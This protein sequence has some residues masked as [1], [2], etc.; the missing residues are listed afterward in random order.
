M[1]RAAA[2]ALSALPMACAAS[3]LSTSNKPSVRHSCAVRRCAQRAVRL[4][5]GARP[6]SRGGRLFGCETTDRVPASGPS[7]RRSWRAQSIGG[8]R[9]GACSGGDGE[10]GG[11]DCA[12]TTDRV[13]ASWASR[14]PRAPR[15]GASRCLCN[16][17]EGVRNSGADVWAAGRCWGARFCAEAMDRRPAS[18]V[19][20]SALSSLRDD[21]EGVPGPPY[22]MFKVAGVVLGP[23]GCAEAMYRRPPTGARSPRPGR[24]ATAHARRHLDDGARLALTR[25]IAVRRARWREWTLVREDL[26]GG[27]GQNSPRR[28]Q[29][30][31]P[32]LARIHECPGRQT[33]A[34]YR[35]W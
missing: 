10:G 22:V 20:T 26:V 31:S 14:R 28:G 11:G 13:P 19:S 21:A 34:K 7:V 29:L 17:L 4:R 33:T 12:E 15:R 23:R 18:G 5:A 16:V 9:R 27:D 3:H 1:F 2:A 8:S 35:F 6:R 30:L 25:Y 24:R 32:A